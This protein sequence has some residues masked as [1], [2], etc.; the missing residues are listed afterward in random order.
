MMLTETLGQEFGVGSIGM[1]RFCFSASGA[2][3]AKIW[4]LRVRPE[5]EA[6]II[7]KA[8]S[9]TSGLDGLEGYDCPPLTPP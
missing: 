9:H 6:G 1:T 5:M 3:A 4:R 2:S 8:C 7:R